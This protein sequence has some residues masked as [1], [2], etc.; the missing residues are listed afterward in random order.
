MYY[1]AFTYDATLKYSSTAHTQA[2]PV[3]LSRSHRC[4]PIGL[5]GQQCCDHG[6]GVLELQGTSKVTFNGMVAQVSSWSATSITAIVPQNATSGFVIV[7]VNGRADQRNNLQGWRQTR[8]TPETS[9]CRLID[10]H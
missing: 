3:N 1:S 9:N 7:T 2:T 6:H 8:C 4:R 5:G 10:S